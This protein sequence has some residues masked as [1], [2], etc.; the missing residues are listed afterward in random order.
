MNPKTHVVILTS[1]TGGGHTSSA[2]ALQHAFQT[3]YGESIRVTIADLWTDYAPWPLNLLPRWYYFFT[4]AL[5]I[6]WLALWKLMALPI[7]ARPFF[8]VI[9]RWVQSQLLTAYSTLEPDVIIAVHPLVQREI[10][11]AHV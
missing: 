8:G 10:G 7:V 3:Q 2:K 9:G 5:P 11:R 4:N 1:A 6:L